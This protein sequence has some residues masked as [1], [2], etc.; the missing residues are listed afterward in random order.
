[1]RRSLTIVC[2]LISVSLNAS[3]IR[4]AVGQRH[5]AM[6][7]GESHESYSAKDYVQDGLVAMWDGIENVGWGIHD[8]N[9]TTWIDLV[10]GRTF[11]LTHGVVTPNAVSVLGQM[12]SSK[13]SYDTTKTYS[14]FHTCKFSNPTHTQANVFTLLTTS[15]AF[16]VGAYSFDANVPVRLFRAVNWK[17][18]VTASTWP[19]NDIYAGQFGIT[20]SVLKSG[21]SPKNIVVLYLDGVEVYR[22]EGAAS[23][24]GYALGD[25]GNYY[26]DVSSS[27]LEQEVYNIRLYNRELT[28]DEIAANYEIDKVRFGL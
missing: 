9:T 6:A 7:T 12:S 14:V 1:M 17:N 2:V 11:L 28:S 25:S 19:D 5:L 20:Y 8:A 24:F 22:L 13:I 23:S 18:V 15:T 27:Q 26:I 3:P 10:G 16:S 21:E 4:S